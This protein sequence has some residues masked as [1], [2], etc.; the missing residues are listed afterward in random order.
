MLDILQFDQ[1]SNYTNM[2]SLRYQPLRRGRKTHLKVQ[3]VRRVYQSEMYSQII[4]FRI[5]CFCL[6]YLF[7]CLLEG[8]G[9][10]KTGKNI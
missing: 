4:V 1:Y 2:R 5:C 8:P 9:V 6:S 10:D 7:L 3:C